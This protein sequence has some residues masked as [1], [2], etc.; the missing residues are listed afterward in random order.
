MK[1]LKFKTFL[2]ANFSPTGIGF[3]LSRKKSILT[4]KHRDQIIKIASQLNDAGVNDVQLSVDGFHDQCL[5][6]QET[7]LAGQALI[8]SGIESVGISPRWL[9]NPDYDHPMNSRTHE[10]L[11][12]LNDLGIPVLKGEP[13][14]PRGN[15]FLNYRDHFTF[16]EIMG[17]E[18]CRDVP[19]A[20]DLTNIRGFCL[21]P[22]GDV[23]ICSNIIIGRATPETIVPLL[24][25]YDPMQSPDLQ[26][27]L[28]EG[29]QGLVKLADQYQ[30]TL[31]SGPFYSVCDACFQYRKALGF[32]QSCNA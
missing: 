32:T 1:P 22:L 9:L 11:D 20:P 4:E 12:K 24:Q 17:N 19:G 31:P 30:I 26:A 5:N 15:A 18:F 16:H 29:L 23:I 6:S 8:D 14:Q 28:L 27:L 10:L 25:Q 3:P 7:F 13:V 2:T 21:S